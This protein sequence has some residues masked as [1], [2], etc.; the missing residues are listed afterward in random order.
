MKI[1]PFEQA[2]LSLICSLQPPGWHD[3]VPSFAFYVP[4]P[5]CRPVKVTLDD[6]IIGIGTGI[7]HGKTG[8]LAHVVVHRDHQRKGVGRSIVDHVVS[9][10]RNSGC[11]SVSL[12]ATEQGFP[13]YRKAGFEE[14]T[15]YVFLERSV[16]AEPVRPQG[17]V[18]NYEMADR[19]DILSMDREISGEER[20]RILDD[21]LAGSYVY[22][23]NG[24]VVGFYLPD[25]GEGLILANNVEAGIALMEVRLSH[26]KTA[27]LPVDNRDGIQFF[28]DA[29]FRETRRATRMVLGD[30][31]SWK[32][33]CMYNRIAG[34]LG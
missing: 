27:V 24:A 8:W 21:R 31:Y 23:E 34:N 22:E 11:K 10:L 17:R 25:L 12:A 29:D 3:I 13:L 14:Q 33:D 7:S 6:E 4:S 1:E 18:R 19:A 2:D 15:Q 32:P 9:L 26:V 20:S 28:T 5:I 16:P 30:R